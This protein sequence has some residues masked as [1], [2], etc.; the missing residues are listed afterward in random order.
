MSAGYF[1]NKF[2][3]SNSLTV[4]LHYQ[5]TNQNTNI[6]TKK[7]NYKV[8]YDGIYTSVDETHIDVNEN[9]G[10]FSTYAKAKAHAIKYMTEIKKEYA[11]SI[12]YLKKA[13]R[14]DRTI[15]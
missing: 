9:S 2:G 6:M 1:E 3:N 13:K 10:V 15:E 5:L 14:A 4:Y 7:I 8:D 12:A 11:L